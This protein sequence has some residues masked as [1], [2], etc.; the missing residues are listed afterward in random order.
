MKLYKLLLGAFSLWSL[1][2][3]LSCKKHI[4]T[5]HFAGIVDSMN[6]VKVKVISMDFSQVY[7]ST[8]IKNNKF[9]LNISLP[10]SDFYVVQFI[11]PASGKGMKWLHPCLVYLEDGSKNTFYANGPYAVLQEYYHIKSSSFDQQKLDE[12]KSLLNKKRKLLY[13]QKQT[14]IKKMDLYLSKRDIKKYNS[15]NDSALLIE[16][17]ITN[18]GRVTMTEFI[19]KN[20]NTIVTPYFM[21]QM[22]DYSENYEL[23]LSVL[24]KLSPEVKRTKYFE[25]A[26]ALLQSFEKIKVGSK[27]PT[28]AGFDKSGKPFNYKYS[29]YKYTLIDFWASY[30]NP[31][32]KDFPQLKNLY[33]KYKNNGFSIVSVSIDDK[34]E[35]W[36]STSTEE[37]IPWYDVCEAMKQEDSKNVQNFVVTSI[38]LNYLLN[39]KGEMIAKNIDLDSLNS[40]LAHKLSSGRN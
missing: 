25:E 29:N 6:G 10:S 9:S 3:A 1:F 28:I 13:S 8:T 15:C 2:A 24:D 35:R 21:T 5:T 4:S 18:V 14:L 39:E 11:S 27:V 22:G 12:Y 30:C 17:A 26:S 19:K 34:K 7:D 38:P 40:F 32:R 37:N 31:C 36:V 16:K 33:A 20:Y 23:Y